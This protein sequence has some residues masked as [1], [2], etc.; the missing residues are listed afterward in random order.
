VDT[1]V[2]EL[3]TTLWITL[4]TRKDAKSLWK[5]LLYLYVTQRKSINH[6]FTTIRKV[7]YGA[8][9]IKRCMIDGNQRNA[10]RVDGNQ[11][12][13]TIIKLYAYNLCV[14]Q[15]KHNEHIAT[16]L[17]LKLYAETCITSIRFGKIQFI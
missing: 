12:N 15:A 13:M 11:S 8:I 10:P 9:N 6:E 17:I 2:N 14:N 7:F 5:K 3:M 4:L 16:C 1:F